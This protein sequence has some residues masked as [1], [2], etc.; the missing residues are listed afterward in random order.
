[1]DEYV[2]LVYKLTRKFSKEELYSVTSQARRATL[3]VILNYIEG[4]ARQK[5]AVK[6]NFWEIS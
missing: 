4:F 6:Q 3:S 2:H 5:R 1:M